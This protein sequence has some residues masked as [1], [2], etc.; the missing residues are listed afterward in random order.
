[1]KKYIY[2]I[3]LLAV[4]FLT[5]TACTKDDFSLDSSA[6]EKEQPVIKTYTMTINASKGEDVATTRALSLDGTRPAPI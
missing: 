2:N 3:S 6:I 4:L 1:M 5:V